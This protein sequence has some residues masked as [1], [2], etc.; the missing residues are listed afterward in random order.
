VNKANGAIL[1]AFSGGALGTVQ[2]M[3]WDAVNS[4]ILV[5]ETGTD[6]VINASTSLT[7]AS[8]ITNLNTYGLTDIEALGFVPSEGRTGIWPT[9]VRI[10]RWQE[11][12]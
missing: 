7:S 1:E 2:G 10:I 9:G 8:Y 4:R 11:K 6:M 12:Q 3:A 5:S